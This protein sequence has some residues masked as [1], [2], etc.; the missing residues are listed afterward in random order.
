MKNCESY[1]NLAC[2]EVKYSFPLRFGRSKILMEKTETQSIKNSGGGEE[3]YGR[4]CDWTK[5]VGITAEYNIVR[6]EQD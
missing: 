1:K 4:T 2:G 5:N 6:A 3:E